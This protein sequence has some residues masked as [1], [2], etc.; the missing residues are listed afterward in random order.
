MLPSIKP[1]YSSKGANPYIEDVPSVERFQEILA[2]N[3]GLVIVKFGAT[4]CGPC[5]S[6]D[7]DIQF[8]YSKMPT[9][10]QCVKIDID[11]NKE[12]YSFLRNKRMINGVPALLCYVKG[13]ENVVPDDIII[14]ANRDKI[15]AFFDRCF[16][17]LNKSHKTS[18]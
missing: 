14:G 8:M 5:Q 12:I 16:Q 17:M 2:S 15:Y 18:S 9:T 11:K 7:P 10:V 3:P 1:R 6:I 4:W 13:N